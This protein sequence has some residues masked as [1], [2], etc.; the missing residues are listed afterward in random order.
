MVNALR[1]SRRVA[2]F[3]RKMCHRLYRTGMIINERLSTD[4]NGKHELTKNR[5]K[6]I[7]TSKTDIHF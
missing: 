7:S 6:N 4:D 1:Q 5:M 2:D 3:P